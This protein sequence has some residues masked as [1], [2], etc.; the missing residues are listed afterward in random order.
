[1][2]TH[3]VTDA[4]ALY[5]RASQHKAGSRYLKTAG[6]TDCLHSPPHDRGFRTAAVRR[7]PGART[8]QDLCVVPGGKCTPPDRDRQILQRGLP[9]AHPAV[10]SDQQG[11]PLIKRRAQDLSVLDT[12]SER[13]SDAVIRTGTVKRIHDKERRIDFQ[14][15]F[16]FTRRKTAHLLRN[17]DHFCERQLSADHFQRSGAF[18]FI[19]KQ[20]G[21]LRAE[22]GLP[23]YEPH[24]FAQDLRR[25][26]K[27]CLRILK[28]PFCRHMDPFREP[29]QRHLPE[30][31]RK[32][33]HDK[34]PVNAR[35]AGKRVLRGLRTEKLQTLPVIEPHRLQP[36]DLS[37]RPFYGFDLS[38]HYFAGAP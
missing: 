20:T 14:F 8:R 6:Q 15:R 18:Q 7:V 33:R 32:R 21:F 38:I 22:R 16:R 27:A 17:R 35:K 23:P 1:M 29:H 26:K 5:R 31:P 37:V 9:H 10:L 34:L 11:F 4:Y 19:P 13:R 24:P 2:I 12:Q 30:D 28:R 36:L 25:R 3:F